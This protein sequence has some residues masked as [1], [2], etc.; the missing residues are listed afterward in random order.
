MGLDDALGLVVPA[1]VFNPS[2]L[3]DADMQH[4]CSPALPAAPICCVRALKGSD[5]L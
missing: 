5:V 2:L 1:F 4:L 3:V